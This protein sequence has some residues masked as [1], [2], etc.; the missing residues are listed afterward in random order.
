MKL[1]IRN[2]IELSLQVLFCIL[3]FFKPF[4]ILS[5]SSWDISSTSKLADLDTDVSIL[6][7]A[8]SKYVGISILHIILAWALICFCVA[9]IVF[10]ILQLIA[11][12][13]KRNSILPVIMCSV[14]GLL[15]IALA[16]T[17]CL[18]ADSS[19]V[20]SNRIAFFHD[21]I[22]GGVFVGCSVVLLALVIL[23]VISFFYVRKRGITEIKEKRN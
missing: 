10:Y 13:K 5:S 6:D 8:I 18:L 3:L 2:I 14:Q 17:V 9:G 19:S 12:G 21:Y 4:F 11:V 1:I 15:L 23:T 22:I 20:N 16:L 7:I